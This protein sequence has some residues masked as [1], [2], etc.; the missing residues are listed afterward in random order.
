[1]Y[2]LSNL[3]FKHL[4][5]SVFEDDEQ[6]LFHDGFGQEKN[7]LGTEGDEFPDDISDEEPAEE[8]ADE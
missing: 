4:G 8:I 1:M 5:F 3:P 6:H 2:Q 7:L